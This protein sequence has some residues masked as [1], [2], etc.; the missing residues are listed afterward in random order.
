MIFDRDLPGL[1]KA[2]CFL[3]QTDNFSEM[4]RRFSS[5]PRSIQF[6][7]HSLRSFRTCK[8]G[9][10]QEKSVDEFNEAENRVFTLI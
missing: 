6:V 7:T 9:N 3:T 2:T 4:R 8:V 10:L 1:K 5:Y